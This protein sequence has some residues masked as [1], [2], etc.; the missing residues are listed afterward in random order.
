M[1]LTILGILALGGGILLIYLALH[2]RPAAA[3]RARRRRSGDG[4]VI[5]LFNDGTDEAGDG[6]EA[7]DSDAGES[8]FTDVEFNESTDAEKPEDDGEK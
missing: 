3:E 7:S 1:Q 2:R 8:A 5:Y 6:S 4:K